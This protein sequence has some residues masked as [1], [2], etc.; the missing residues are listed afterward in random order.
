MLSQI[1]CV[2]S[3]VLWPHSVCWLSFLVFSDFFVYFPFSLDQVRLFLLSNMVLH[4]EAL[5]L[6]MGSYKEYDHC[7]SHNEL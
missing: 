6:V 5:L 4:V 2:D 3:A 1:L 7:V